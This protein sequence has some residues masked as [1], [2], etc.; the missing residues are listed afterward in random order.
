M[1]K[2]QDDEL[3]G[4]MIGGGLIGSALGALLSDKKNKEDGILLGAILGAIV[5]GSFVANQRASQGDVPVL[6]EEGNEIY[7]IT[8]KDKRLVKTLPKNEVEIP[9]RFRLKK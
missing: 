2:A 7:E 4:K 9:L 5:S 3:I 6:V 8:S 1:S